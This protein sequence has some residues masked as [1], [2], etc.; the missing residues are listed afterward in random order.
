MGSAY[1]KAARTKAPQVTRCIDPFH[2]VKLANDALDTTR[3]WAWHH[4]RGRRPESGPRQRAGT[5]SRPMRR[6]AR[7]STPGGRC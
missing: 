2:V 3:R 7:S 1:A 6:S 4:A 5:H